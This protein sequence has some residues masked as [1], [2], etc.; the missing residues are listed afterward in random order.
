MWFNCGKSCYMHLK[1]CYEYFRVVCYC[2][3][4]FRDLVCNT[5][6]EKKIFIVETPKRKLFKLEFSK[7]IWKIFSVSFINLLL[8]TTLKRLELS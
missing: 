4:S 8:K 2:P 1:H 6:K 3:K 7:N 5:Q